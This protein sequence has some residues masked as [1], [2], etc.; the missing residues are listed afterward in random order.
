MCLSHG[1]NQGLTRPTKIRTSEVNAELV[2][3]L[4]I[5]AP[6][7]VRIHSIDTLG[8]IKIGQNVCQCV[9]VCRIPHVPGTGVARRGT[10]HG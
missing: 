6:H 1:F 10:D 5:R 4:E 8:G 2:L 7:T 3:G 9:C